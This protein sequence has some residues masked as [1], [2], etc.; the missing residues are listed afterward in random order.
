MTPAPTL[1]AACNDVQMRM[2]KAIAFLRYAAPWRGE[3]VNAVA[4]A[5]V[6]M[7]LAADELEE[8]LETDASAYVAEGIVRWLPDRTS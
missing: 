3:I 7:L 4:D 8:A 2:E 5:Y 1:E 6:G